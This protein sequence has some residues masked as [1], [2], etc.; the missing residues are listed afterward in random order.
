MARKT[1]VLSVSISPDVLKDYDRLARQERTNRSELFRRM[2]ERYRIE[3]DLAEFKRVQAEVVAHLNRGR[4]KP[5]TE[6]DIE[7]MLTE[8]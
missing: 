6:A 7:R 1:K 8:D 3:A 4:K 2:V 5:L